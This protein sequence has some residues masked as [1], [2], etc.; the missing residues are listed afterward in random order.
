MT[1]PTFRP[2]SRR[3]AAA[4]ELATGAYCWPVVTLKVAVGAFRKGERFFGVPSSTPGAC[5]LAN[6][7]FCACPDYQRRGSGCKHQR[8]V[9]LHLAPLEAASADARV[10]LA[11][12]AVSPLAGPV[13]QTIRPDRYSALFPAED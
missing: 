8:A 4:A 12:A 1:A 3:A 5:Y 10:E 13:V 11:F 9:V 2:D 6:E 7:R